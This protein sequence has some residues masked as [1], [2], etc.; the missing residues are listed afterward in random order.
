MDA[1]FLGMN[2]AGRKTYDWL[3]QRDDVDVLAVLTEEEQLSLVREL[4]PELV[5]SSGFEH[6]V[7]EEII[8]VPEKGIVNLH[9]S[10]LPYNRGAHPYIW[11][12]VEDT[13]AGVSIHYMNEE[14]DKGDLIARREVEVLEKDTA[15]DLYD[16]LQQEQSELFRENWDEIRDGADAREQP[17]K[18]TKH[19]RE[20]LDELCHLDLEEKERLGDTID[21]LRALTFSDRNTA[22]FERNG[23]KYYVR[24]DI[25][26]D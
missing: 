24:I 14:V 12:I 3:N 18:G 26:K 1:I 19:Y 4:E 17:V 13:P 16:R 7:P 11:P 20:D 25:E 21:R 23:E 5:I 22:F 15:G 6:I 2:E 8:E 10:F 9:P